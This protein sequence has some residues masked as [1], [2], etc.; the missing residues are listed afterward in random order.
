MC[1]EDHFS[2]KVSR[3]LDLNFVRDNLAMVEEKL[4][5]RGANAAEVLKDF[6]A[7]DAERFLESRET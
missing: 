1:T 7:I 4:R 6:A 3:M 5:H 2:A